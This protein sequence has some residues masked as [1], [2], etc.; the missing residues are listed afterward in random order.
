MVLHGFCFCLSRV[1]YHISH[2]VSIRWKQAD[3]PQ[4]RLR[5][6]MHCK[7]PTFAEL[8]DYNFAVTFSAYDFVMLMFGS[9]RMVS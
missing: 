3:R 9:V 7:A 4:A 1:S 2:T 6:H 5:A 8:Y